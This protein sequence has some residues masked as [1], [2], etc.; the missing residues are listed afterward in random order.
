MSGDVA[1]I[2]AFLERRPSEWFCFGPRHTHT[3]QNES[4]RIYILNRKKDGPWKNSPKLEIKTFY[5]SHF[6][7]TF[8][9]AQKKKKNEN[10]YMEWKVWDYDFTQNYSLLLISRDALV[11]KWRDEKNE[12]E[13]EDEKYE[14]RLTAEISETSSV[15]AC[16]PWNSVR[17]IF[18]YSPCFVLNCFSFF[19]LSLWFFFFSSSLLW[20]SLGNF[21]KTPIPQISY[22]ATLNLPGTFTTAASWKREKK[23]WF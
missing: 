5:D 9:T 8:L 11:L 22:N 10:S 3:Q 7:F 15:G 2:N 23:N 17:T 12:S 20:S 4:T 14:E 18:T 1:R 19:S 13:N 6:F 16:L 21:V